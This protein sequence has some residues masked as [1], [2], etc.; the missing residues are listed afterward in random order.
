[1]HKNRNKN[2]SQSP[3][4]GF[5]KSTVNLSGNAIGKQ[6]TLSGADTQ[7]IEKVTKL[8]VDVIRRQRRLWRKE[9]NDW[10]A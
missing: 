7:N 10:Q 9:L 2:R 6:V 4:K 3:I 8:M 5:T 1:M